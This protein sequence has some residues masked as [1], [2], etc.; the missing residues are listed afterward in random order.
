[1]NFVD[2]TKLK[3]GR[4]T[5][6]RLVRTSN[7][8]SF[9]LCKCTCGTTLTVRGNALQ[10]KNTKSCGCLARENGRKQ[11]LTT[12][13]HGHA[14][15]PTRTKIYRIWQGM[16]RRCYTKS[17]SGYPNYG[18]RGIKVAR[19]W[20]KFEN[21]LADMGQP[22]AGLSLDRINNNGNYSKSNCRWATRTEQS[23]NSSRTK[24]ITF[25]GK[26]QCIAAWARELSISNTTLWRKLS[27]GLSLSEIVRC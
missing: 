6:I 26:R 8:K 14:A 25:R 11:G 22:K 17:A 9:W 5:V 13:K 20:K 19:P 18:A 23:A 16:L 12:K 24:L 1:M 7:K 21:F 3:Y 4:L 27:K 15:H 2:R 10:S